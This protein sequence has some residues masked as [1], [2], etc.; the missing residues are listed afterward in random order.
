M[1][2]SPGKLSRRT[3]FAGASTVGAVA[4]VASLMPA[5]QPVLPAAQEPKAAPAKGGGYSPD[6]ARQALLQDDPHLTPIVGEFHVIDQKNPR[7]PTRPPGRPSFTACVAAWPRPCRP[8][9]VVLS[10]VVPASAWASVWRLRS[11]HW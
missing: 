5:V 4:T 9:T 1:S 6:R 8:W 7:P 3:L 2:Q 10:C 11:S